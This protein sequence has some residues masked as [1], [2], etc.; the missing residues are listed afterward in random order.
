MSETPK[1]EETPSATEKAATFEQRIENV[2]KDVLD[3]KLKALD[4]RIDKIIEDKLSAKE[5]EVEHAL[6]KTFGT[7]TDPVIHVS[8]LKAELRKMTL[9]NVEKR[10]PAATEKAAPEGNKPQDPIDEQFKQYGV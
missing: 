3:V 10:S 9:D 5:I 1:K 6:R 7:E 4:L 2:I 8:D